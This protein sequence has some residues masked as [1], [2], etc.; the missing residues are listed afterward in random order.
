M[1]T[2]RLDR[3]IISFYY[4]RL[5]DVVIA[6][7]EKLKA[8]DDREFDKPGSHR[9]VLSGGWGNGKHQTVLYNGK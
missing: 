6:A 5:T 4:K 8:S 2:E 7:R 3:L 9:L 1:S